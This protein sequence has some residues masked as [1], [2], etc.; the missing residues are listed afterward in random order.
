MRYEI[1]VAAPGRKPWHAK[2]LWTAKVK[3]NL[4]SQLLFNLKT[5]YI[6]DTKTGQRIDL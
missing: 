3:A 1:N 6:I 5:V 4:R 2:Y